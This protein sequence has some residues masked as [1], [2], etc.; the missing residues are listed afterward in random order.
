LEIAYYRASKTEHPDLFYGVASSFGTLG[1]LTLI[2]MRLIP[3]KKYVA[4]TYHPVSSYAES[5][6]KILEATEDPSIDYIDGILYSRSSGAI[7]TGFLTDD[8]SLGP[9]QLF[10]RRKDQWFYLRARAAIS[11]Q[12]KEP[13]TDIIPLTDYLF[14]YDRGAFW[15][16]RY[17]YKYFIAPF[18]RFSRWVLDY[19]MHTRVLYHALHESGLSNYYLIQD[20]ALPKDKI[21]RFLEYVDQELGIY[22][23][24]IC[25]LKP[26]RTGIMN[27][28]YKEG[29]GVMINVGVWGPGPT[30]REKFVEANQ[31]LEKT[32]RDLGGVKW[33]Y[34]QTYY[35]EEEFWGIYDRKVYDALRDKYGASGLPTV[36]DKVGSNWEAEQKM[37][38]EASF[39]K[40]VKLKGKDIWPLRGYYG[41]AR[42]ILGKNYLLAEK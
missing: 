34:A 26:D 16:G 22:P 14:R 4:L 29:D 10:S 35:S 1:V 40:R 3:A 15:T 42:T 11:K 7:M 5:I 31:R 8:A 17:A 2:E 37:R 12:R 38:K 33:L 25:P 32:V 18:D 6:S 24:W 19:F 9:L 20:L 27:P 36:Y 28:Y 41:L 39:A 13:L 30:N 23:L 21:E